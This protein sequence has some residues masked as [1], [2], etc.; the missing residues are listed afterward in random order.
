MEYAADLSNQAVANSAF[1]YPGVYVPDY[2]GHPETLLK[3]LDA[4]A[5]QGQ[6][7]MIFDISYIDQFNWWPILEKAYPKEV[8]AP[9][10]TPGLL[11]TIRG[12][13][14]AVR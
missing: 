6:G 12:A 1:V 8:P 5:K 3:A 14:D 13:M 2:T 9:H 4:A 11:S 7:W 10:A